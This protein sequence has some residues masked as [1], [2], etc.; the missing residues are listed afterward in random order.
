MSRRV[1]V[2]RPVA[3]LDV[4]FHGARCDLEDVGS[5]GEHAKVIYAGRDASR[6]AGRR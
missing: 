1:L 6:Q 4:K 2:P 5:D 3:E